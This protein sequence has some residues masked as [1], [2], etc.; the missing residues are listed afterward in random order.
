MRNYKTV[1][2]DTWD[3]I[4]KN[5]YGDER[6]MSFLLQANYMLRDIVV[7]SA[8]VDI[9]VPDLPADAVSLDLPP[10]RRNG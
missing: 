5:N 3:I 4:A 6:R 1:Q 8:G 2:G 9:A 7:F 10:W